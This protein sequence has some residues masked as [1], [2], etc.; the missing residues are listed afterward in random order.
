M[1]KG[2]FR[3]DF[4]WLNTPTLWIPPP[5]DQNTQADLRSLAD[6]RSTRSCMDRAGDHTGTSIEW[7][8]I[9]NKP[10]ISSFV[11]RC[12]LNPSAAKIH[13]GSCI[14]CR[15]V[16]SRFRMSLHDSESSPSALVSST[17]VEPSLDRGPFQCPVRF[18]STCATARRVNALLPIIAVIPYNSTR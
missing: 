13:D 12:R 5:T 10:A 18:R 14:S 1:A 2:R 11:L 6:V 15:L 3:E 9:V 7:R 17:S 16:G 8:A 4:F